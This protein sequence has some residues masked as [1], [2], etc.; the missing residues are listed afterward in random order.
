M[1]KKI[2]REGKFKSKG[3]NILK[4]SPT[5]PKSMTEFL[6]HP[7]EMDTSD[8]RRNMADVQRHNGTPAQ[9][10]RLRQ[11]EQLRIPEDS[12]PVTDQIE[13]PVP[14]E[15]ARIHV[16]IK[17]DLADKLVEAVFNRKRDRSCQR[18]DATQRVIIEQALETWF[19]NHPV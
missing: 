16:H 1:D 17:K 8:H 11:S 7:G 6:A 12:G 14:N 9:K 4:G 13:D 5:G 18:K 10:H 15:I 2:G 3:V 19:E